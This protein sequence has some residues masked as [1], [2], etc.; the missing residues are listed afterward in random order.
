M[1]PIELYYPTARG[2]TDHNCILS[3][4]SKGIHTNGGCQCLR[5]LQRTPLGFDAARTIRYL[6]QQLKDIME[7]SDE[8]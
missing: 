2:C 6:R 4:N 7:N 1:K 8:P 3:D 5:E